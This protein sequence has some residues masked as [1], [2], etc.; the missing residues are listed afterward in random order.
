MKTI[1][2]ILVF[3]TIA[4]NSCNPI[5]TQYNA[6]AGHWYCN[7]IYMYLGDDM[8]LY[9]LKNAIEQ[10][11]DGDYSYSNDTI[12]FNYFDLN[13]NTYNTQKAAY[14]LTDTTLIINNEIFERGYNE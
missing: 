12:V 8:S 4:I 11:V 1:K 6:L 9:M 3:V 7:D 14:K 13:I 5:R 2:I 10:W